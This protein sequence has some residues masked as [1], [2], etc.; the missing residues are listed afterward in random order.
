[1]NIRKL[2][3]EI[4]EI[5]SGNKT[6][7]TEL[8]KTPQKIKETSLKKWNFKKNEKIVLQHETNISIETRSMNRLLKAIE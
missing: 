5:Y 8:K 3:N 6:Q 4:K 2:K 1:M 7:N